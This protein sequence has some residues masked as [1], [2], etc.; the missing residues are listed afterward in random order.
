MKRIPVHLY[1]LVLLVVI[2]IAAAAFGASMYVNRNRTELITNAVNKISIDIFSTETRVDILKESE[3]G[4]VASSTIQRELADLDDRLTF[5]EDQLGERNAD[6]FRLRRYYGL[7]E[8]KSYL[9]GEKVRKRCGAA[10]PAL[11]YIH[12]NDSSCSRCTEEEYVLEALQSSRPELMVYRLDA[13]YDMAALKAYARAIKEVPDELPA[14]ILNDRPFGGFKTVEEL[15]A[16][17]ASSTA[18]SS[19]KKASSK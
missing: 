9:I 11:V 14:F 16:M 12:T 1:I 3:C 18:T 4:T 19:P 15:E 17:I 10:D 7:L 2:A 13:R 8:I 6:I 5:M